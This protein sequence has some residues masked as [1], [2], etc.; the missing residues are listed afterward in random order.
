MLKARH[1]GNS[2]YLERSPRKMLGVAS[3]RRVEHAE[4]L[5]LQT[6]AWWEETVLG[7]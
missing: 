6:K 1:A 3:N 7:R 2:L 5:F 4:T